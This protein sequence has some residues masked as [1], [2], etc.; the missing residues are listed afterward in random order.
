M[1]ERAST[2][3]M[4]VAVRWSLSLCAAVGAACVCSLPQVATAQERGGKP[5]DVEASGAASKPKALTPAE[6]PVPASLADQ[7]KL[8]RKVRFK[9]LGSIRKTEIRQIG[10]AKLSEFTDPLIFPKM[11]EI[12]KKDKDDVRGALLNHFADQNSQ[13]GDATLAWCAVF[14]ADEWMRAESSRR[15]VRRVG[16]AREAGSAARAAVAGSAA[17]PAHTPSDPLVDPDVSWRVKKIVS[18]GLMQPDDTIAGAAAE[19]AEN[20]N[21]IEAIPQ[22]INLQVQR[23]AGSAAGIGPRAGNSLAFIQVG[24]QQAFVSDL[25]PVVG[26]SA[27]AFDPTISVLTEGSVLSVSDA[28]V[29]TYRTIIHY[30]L[31]RLAN[32]NWNGGDTREFAM[33]QKKWADWYTKEFRP[34][35]EQVAAGLIEHSP[36][37]K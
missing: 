14:D 18:N 5:S 7:E 27:V 22:M 37:K 34:Y 20:L 9:Y 36:K 11:L 26:D 32:A 31:T 2:V 29:T 15:L 21:L 1:N 4:G 24:R 33:D 28:V 13:E 19:L 8:L 10:L 3:R 25:T 6:E 17:S 23:T 12:F 16:M 35:R 30:P